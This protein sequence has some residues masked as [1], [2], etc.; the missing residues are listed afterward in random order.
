MVKSL[1][2]KE[3][4]KLSLWKRSSVI[5]FFCFVYFCLD[6]TSFLAGTGWEVGKGGRQGDDPGESPV[7]FWW[8]KL[9]TIW[10]PGVV[11]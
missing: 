10:G 1:V 4:S 8:S 7:D 11:P 2:S 3:V 6:E 5:N 9:D